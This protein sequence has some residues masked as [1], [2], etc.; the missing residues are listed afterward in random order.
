M[1]APYRVLGARAR[2]AGAHR[3]GITNDRLASSSCVPGDRARLFAESREA[4]VSQS[5]GCEA[6]HQKCATW[7]R[8]AT[9][10]YFVST[11]V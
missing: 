11:G 1:L 9:V 7:M 4:V 8:L 10:Q 5:A 3:L 2:F 6:R